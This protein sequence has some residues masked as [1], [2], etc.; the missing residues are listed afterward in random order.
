MSVRSLNWVKFGG[1]VGLAFVLGL[2]FAGLLDLPKPSVAQ[3]RLT[4]ATTVARAKTPVLA[5]TRPLA[6]LSEAF[7]DVAE[8]VRASV[9]YVRSQR[10]ERSGQRRLPPG[11]EDF[12]FGNPRNGRQPQIE[13]GSG[14]GFIVS[15]DGYILTNN[16]VVDGADQVMVRLPDRHEYTAKVVGTD[17]TTDVAVIKIDAK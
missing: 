12:F 7:A 3:P 15:S 2:L 1:L 16:H 13:R 11:F 10:T 5:S 4:Q 8:H 9:V 14:S 17:A 6:D